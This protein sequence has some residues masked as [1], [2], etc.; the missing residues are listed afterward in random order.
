MDQCLKV[1]RI[2]CSCSWIVPFLF[3]F[4]GGGLLSFPLPF[5]VFFFHE[6]FATMYL[7]APQDQCEYSLKKRAQL[8]Q[9]LLFIYKKK[10]TKILV[11]DI[12]FFFEGVRISHPNKNCLKPPHDQY[13]YSLESRAQSVQQLPKS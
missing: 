7:K 13:V 10:E 5:Y 11:G 6:S 8:G 4:W 9:Q 12:F 2:T 1:L 3:F